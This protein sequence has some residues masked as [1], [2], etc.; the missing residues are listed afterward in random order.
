[1][2]IILVDAA[3]FWT[4]HCVIV[5]RMGKQQVSL[6]QREGREGMKRELVSEVKK[7]KQN[8]TKKTGKKGKSE[9]HRG[10]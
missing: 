3:V 8:K 2:A 5:R 10:F 9:K 1:M 6:V 4:G 7:T